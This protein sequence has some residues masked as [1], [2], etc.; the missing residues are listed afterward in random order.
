MA[1]GFNG[2]AAEAAVLPRCQREASLLA[3]DRGYVAEGDFERLMLG[4]RE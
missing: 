1:K 4:L 3:G 2:F